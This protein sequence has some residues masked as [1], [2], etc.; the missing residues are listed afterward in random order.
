MHLQN[1]FAPQH[2]QNSDSPTQMSYAVIAPMPPGKGHSCHVMRKI[3]LF[4]LLCVGCPLIANAATPPNII[5]ILADD[6]GYGDLGCYG[7]PTIR[8]PH[9]DR[10]AAEGMRFTDF[11]S[12]G[13]VC[14]PSRAALLTGRYAVRSGMAGGQRRVLFPNSVGGLPKTEIT[15]ATALKGVGYATGM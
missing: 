6:L 12:A 14:T 2:A 5:I 1:Q 3:L 9:L 13:E 4:A 7:H 10:M 8:T 11:Y 15:I